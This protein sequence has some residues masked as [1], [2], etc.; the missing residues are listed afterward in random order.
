MPHDHPIVKD[1]DDPNFEHSYD[2][3]NS[4]PIIEAKADTTTTSLYPAH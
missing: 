3:N 1:V 2:S 4:G